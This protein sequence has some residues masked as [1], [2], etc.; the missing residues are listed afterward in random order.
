LTLQDV[1][2]DGKRFVFSGSAPGQG[3]K[4]YVQDLEGGEAQSIAPEGVNS[5]LFAISLDGKN[6]AAIGPDQKGYIYPIDGRDPKLIPGL[7]PYEGPIAW[8]EDGQSLFIYRLGEMPTK[9]Y[10]LNIATGKRQFVRQLMP[11]DLSGVTDISGVFI[12]PDGHAYVYEYGQTLSD[13]YLVSD[14]K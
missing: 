12:T 7:E 9:I 11:P 6:V 2:P 14:V 5:S 10:R 8:C 1:A 13:L 3:V 4:L